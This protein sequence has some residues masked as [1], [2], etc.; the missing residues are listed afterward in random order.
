MPVLRVHLL[1]GPDARAVA[2][3]LRE[4][5][6][7]GL[8]AVTAAGEPGTVALV[9][10]TGAGCPDERAADVLLDGGPGLME[11]V[12]RLWSERLLPFAHRMAGQPG[13][14]PGPPVLRP[15]DP[16][17]LD[18]AQRMLGRIRDGLARRGLDDG[19]WT[20]DHIGST[21]VPG[22][23]A[24]PFIDLQLGAVCLPKE[25]SPVDEVLAAAGFVPA[26]GARPDSPGVYRDEVKDPGLAPADAYRK[27]L[28]IRPDPGQRAILH[29][30]RLGTPWWSY[31]VRFRDWLRDNPAGRRAYEQMK[32]RAAGAHAN[33]A[34]FDGYTRA[35]EAFFG[36]VQGEYE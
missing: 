28:Y 25:D 7:A 10:A 3:R 34:D 31:T 2:V 6:G 35:K 8:L 22:L 12:D 33:D 18:A 5:D 14:K 36:Q 27:R 24:K 32:Q 20:Y 15:H 21:A 26:R 1:P 19:R 29:V 23:R 9:I 17:L 16:R 11:Q 30:R 13:G 4:H